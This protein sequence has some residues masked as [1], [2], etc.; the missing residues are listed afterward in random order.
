[1][2]SYWS[3]ETKIELER[4]DCI[5]SKTTYTKALPQTSKKHKF[6]FTTSLY[7]IKGLNLIL[8]DKLNIFLKWG[9][10]YV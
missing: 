10:R 2:V 7:L 1:M 6:L 9:M 5:C 4:I 8:V 3:Y